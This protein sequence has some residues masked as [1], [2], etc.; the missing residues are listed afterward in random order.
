MRKAD[1]EAAA[2]EAE[3]EAEEKLCARAHVYAR[4]RA[5]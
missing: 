5:A 4:I 2:A 1:K 3:A